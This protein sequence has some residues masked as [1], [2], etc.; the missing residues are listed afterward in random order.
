MGFA[1]ATVKNIDLSG[2]RV[3]LRVDF[4]VPVDPASGKIIDDSRLRAAIPTIEYLRTNGARILMCS[5]LGRPNGRRVNRL[6][7]TDV[8]VRMSELLGQEISDAG[9]PSGPEPILAM[10]SLQSGQLA[11]MENLR[12]DP[13]E[14]KNDKTFS[15][16][17][18][19]L[20]D[21]YVNDAFGVSHRA[22]SSTHGVASLLPG[23]GGLLLEKEV[24]MLG[25]VVASPR[26]PGVAIIGGAKVVDKI[27]VLAN[28]AKS[29]DV[30]LIGGGMA[31]AF[32]TAQDL[33]G[34][35]AK[36]TQAELTVSKE[37]LAREHPRV[38]CPIDVVVA[39]SIDT[40][41]IAEIVPVD[42]VKDHMLIL[43][44]GPKTADL[45][46]N[47]I[48]RARTV[49]WNGPLGVA[50][51][52]QFSQGSNSIAKAIAGAS[53]AVTVVGGGSTAGVVLGLGLGDSMTHV[54][55]GGGAALAFL[56]GKLLP[57]VAAL[58]D[59]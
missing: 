3:L 17:L 58:D 54:S 7:M 35:A 29:V 15:L 25:L 45:Y 55:T 28:L 6:R 12:F 51:F 40:N 56:E 16:E 31:S 36:V 33:G 13:R 5:H 38:L 24:E 44:I 10:R 37:L 30:I 26:R 34:G 39:E 20:A 14:E 4:N 19:S 18:A 41:A 23:V 59:C 43:D 22:H 53:A 42:S 27:A 49:I 11:L 32:L 52:P 1:K 57:G 47:E 50:E 48:A 21:V 2:K 9:G 8:R 46:A